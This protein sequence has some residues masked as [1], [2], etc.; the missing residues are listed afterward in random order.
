MTRTPTAK[1]AFGVVLMSVLLAFLLTGFVSIF[2]G[3]DTDQKLLVYISIF[4][5]QGFMAV[6]LV[7]YLHKNNISLVK[8]LRLNP[9]SPMILAGT[10]L[11]ALGTVLISEEFDRL[12]EF[13]IADPESFE[14]I[15]QF[16]QI[17]S[18]SS[19]V[20]LFLGIAIFAPIG[21]ELLFRGYLLQ[22][23]ENHW[24]DVTRAILVTALAFAI[25]HLNPY[26]VVQAYL[27]GVVLGYLSWRTDSVLPAIVCHGVYNALALLITNL[28]PA[29]AAFY[30][31]GSHVS[32]FWLLLAAGAI[33]AG[34]Y[35]LNFRREVSA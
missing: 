4:I 21:E 25:I 8:A 29:G 27:M 17:E 19:G 22:A 7:I 1:T 24:Q 34:F 18:F 2:L 33:I 5:G 30:R 32:P 12:I 14:Q 16:L 10:V 9:V 3:P 35:L 6:P 31:W 23:L 20:I 13:F 15:E 11:I 26:W 28:Y